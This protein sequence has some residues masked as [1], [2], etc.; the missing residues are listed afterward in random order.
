MNYSLAMVSL[1]VI[2]DVCALCEYM[3]RLGALDSAKLCDPAESLAFAEKEDG[4]QQLSFL[5]DGRKLDYVVYIDK[6]IMLSHYGPRLGSFVRFM[7]TYGLDMLIKKGICHICDFYY[8]KGVKYGAKMSL[9]E[10]HKFLNDIGKGRTHERNDGSAKL[11]HMAFMECIKS[12]C[13]DIGFTQEESGNKNM[14]HS[15]SIYMANAIRADREWKQRRE[16]NNKR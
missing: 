5:S 8:R 13:N 14:M 4:Y 11:T 15:L 1:S 7:R 3:F 9:S 16:F 2:R 12:E 6:L 10:A